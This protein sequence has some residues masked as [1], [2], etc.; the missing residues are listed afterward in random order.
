MQKP[1]TRDV[2]MD[3]IG[4]PCPQCGHSG[5]LH[6][7]CVNTALSACLICQLVNVV[8]VYIVDELNREWLDSK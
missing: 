8:E 5:A 4:T 6:P 2:T 3:L 1:C 7:S